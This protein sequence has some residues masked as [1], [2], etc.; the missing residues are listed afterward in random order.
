MANGL[1]NVMFQ[2]D[3][4]GGQRTK[5]YTREDNLW[6]RHYVCSSTVKLSC[7]DDL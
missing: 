7:L 5:D 1:K 6:T 4:N 3:L 2:P